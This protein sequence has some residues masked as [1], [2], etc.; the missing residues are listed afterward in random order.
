[1]V[2][3]ENVHAVSLLPISLSPAHARKQPMS[4]R[5]RPF[6]ALLQ[7]AH[8]NFKTRNYKMPVF[9]DPHQLAEPFLQELPV[10]FA[11]YDAG[12]LAKTIRSEINRRFGGELNLQSATVLHE[13][14]Q[15]RHTA[16]L[17]QYAS[18]NWQDRVLS[19]ARWNLIIGSEN[20]L[21]TLS[22]IFPRT[23]FLLR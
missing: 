23:N 10:R 22:N 3:H 12:P 6:V 21:P 5:G 9:F 13:A 16:P 7:R 15:A 17:H 11:T 4:R 14:C 19:S 20:D 1:M 18:I 2:T 8:H